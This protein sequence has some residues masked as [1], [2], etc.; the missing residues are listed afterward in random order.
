MKFA[1]TVLVTLKIFSHRPSSLGK[2]A[3]ESVFNAQVGFH[4]S[5]ICNMAVN[6]DS[7]RSKIS[8]CQKDLLEE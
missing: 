2:N 4:K 7:T 3:V 6:R 8:N 1:L 5:E